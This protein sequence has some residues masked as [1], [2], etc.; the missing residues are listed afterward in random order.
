MSSKMTPKAPL[1]LLSTRLIGQILDTSKILKKIKDKKKK[2]THYI[3]LN[4][5]M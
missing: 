2:E 1:I 5:L 4:L 3:V